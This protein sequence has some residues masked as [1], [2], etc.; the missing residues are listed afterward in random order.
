MKVFDGLFGRLTVK[1]MT[2]DV[3]IEVFDEGG[4]SSLYLST[5]QARKL[6]EHLVRQASI[7][8]A[9]QD[10]LRSRRG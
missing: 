9:A 2:H 6:G 7:I 4:I 8:E 3:F 10:K 5:R 1:E